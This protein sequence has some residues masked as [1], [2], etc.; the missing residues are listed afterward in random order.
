MPSRTVRCPLGMVPSAIGAMFSSMV[1]FLLTR[2]SSE[3]SI[4]FSE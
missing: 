4:A 1:P 2:S 3:C